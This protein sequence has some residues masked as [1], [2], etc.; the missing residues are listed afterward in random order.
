MAAGIAAPFPVPYSKLSGV[1]APDGSFLASAGE[2]EA[3]LIAD[4]DAAAYRQSVESNPYLT[5]LRTA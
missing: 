2:G 3:L 1:A 5:D 4:V